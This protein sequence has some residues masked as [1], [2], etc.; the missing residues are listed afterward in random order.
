[1]I[2]GYNKLLVILIFPLLLTGCWDYKDVNK[3]SIDLSIGVDDVK[4]NL[5]F[6]GE[7]AK[8]AS[9]TSAKGQA[10]ITEVYK[11]ISVGKY[12]EGSRVDYDAKMPF[13]DFSGAVRVVV[14]SKKYGEKIGIES[15]IN[16]LNF[17]NE[18]RNSVLVAISEE[19]TNELYSGTVENDISI[20]YAI[21]NTIRSLNDEGGALYKTVQEIVSDI[22]F[23]ETGYLLP[24]ITKDKNVIKCLG[25]A[26]MKNS[27]LVGIV[28]IGDITGYLFI[29]SKNPAITTAVPHPRNEKNLINTKTTL[30]NRTIK[31]Y[32]Q[33]NN[34]NIYLDLKL[35]TQIQYEYSIES[36]GKED[37]KKIENI[38]SDKVQKDILSALNRSKNDFQ[39][40]VFNF[41]RYFK[42]Q[43]HEEFKKTDWKKAYSTAVFHVSVK[44]TIISTNTFDPNA[45]IP[46]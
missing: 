43:N 1:M 5:E 20:G 9:N 32:Y 44:T 31:T 39:C 37:I 11:Y 15:Y 25:L 21:E 22:E 6:T 19:P 35:N 29:L 2:R 46:D 34:L 41:A 16:R 10:Q 7:I 36:I 17:S 24:Y 3:R 8:L 42:A 13:P 27:K 33:D 38:I 14:F 28:K 23:K 12:F 18:F 30:K 40:D 4:G 45:K 26:A